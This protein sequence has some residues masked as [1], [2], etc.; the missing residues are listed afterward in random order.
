MLVLSRKIGE[1]IVIDDKITLTVVEVS[2]NRIRLGITAPQE[3]KIYRSEVYKL[4]VD[5]KKEKP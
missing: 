1:S 2:G 3:I 5:Q 4:L